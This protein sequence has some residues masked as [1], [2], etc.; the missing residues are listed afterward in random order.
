VFGVGLGLSS[1]AAPNLIV[2]SVPAGQ[3]GIATGMNTNIRTI[4]G[5]VGTTIFSAVIGATVG[6]SGL[7]TEGGYI[8]AFVVGAALAAAAGV[9]PFFAR[10]GRIRN[11][12]EPY[13]V[14][15]TPL[16][17]AEASV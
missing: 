8:A 2:R 13:P 14:A 7:A 9:V 11:R 4:G 15:V 5:A 6:A 12:R 1:S 17:E 16:A 10:P 3:V